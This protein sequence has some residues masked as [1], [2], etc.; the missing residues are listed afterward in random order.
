M[1]MILEKEEYK[2]I[3]Q[4]IS[5]ALYAFQELQVDYAAKYTDDVDCIFEW[6]EKEPHW[7]V[8]AKLKE[9]FAAVNQI[10]ANFE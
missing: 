8:A 7:S 6:L 2:N 1:K 5:N 10:K 9:I 3:D 4:A